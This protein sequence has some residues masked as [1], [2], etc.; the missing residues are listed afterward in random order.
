MISNLSQQG[1]KHERYLCAMLIPLMV[2]MF[3]QG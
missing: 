2:L 3:Y 1:V